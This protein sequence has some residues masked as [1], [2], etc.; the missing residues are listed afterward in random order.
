MNLILNSYTMAG[1]KSNRNIIKIIKMTLVVVVFFK[2][3]KTNK[4]L[5]KY[6][7][8]ITRFTINDTTYKLYKISIVY[9]TNFGVNSMMIEVNRSMI[10][11]STKYEKEIVVMYLM[12][13]YIET[14][15]S[16]SKSSDFCI[17]FFFKV[18]SIFLINLI[19]IISLYKI[20]I[21]VYSFLSALF[22]K[23]PLASNLHHFL[24]A[25][26]SR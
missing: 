10:T 21:Y 25:S 20:N 1:H 26:F 9:F 18:L 5:L 13:K 24:F 14:K 7:P 17:L 11:R 19:I 4:L 3:Y 2:P 23:Y 16:A 15:N 12:Q 6:F 8:A 22:H